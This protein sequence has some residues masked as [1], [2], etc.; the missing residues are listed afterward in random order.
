MSQSESL[1][2]TPIYYRLLVVYVVSS[3]YTAVVNS[4]AIVAFLGAD[5]VVVM[6][7]SLLK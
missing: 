4:W 3:V 2:C 6:R 5:F 1:T 7:M